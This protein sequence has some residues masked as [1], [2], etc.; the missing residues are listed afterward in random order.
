VQYFGYGKFDGVVGLGWS[1]A[2]VGNV[3]SLIQNMFDQ[4][5][6]EKKVFAFYLRSEAGANEGEVTFGGVDNSKFSGELFYQTLTSK[7]YWQIGLDSVEV[8][9]TLL[10]STKNAIFATGTTG[11]LGP[12]S[13]VQKI[14]VVALFLLCQML[15]SILGDRNSQ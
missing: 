10:N 12:S 8:N 5:V 7:N 15:N 1:S 2:A 13:D 3:K 4:K 14:A 11:L 9:G 6:I